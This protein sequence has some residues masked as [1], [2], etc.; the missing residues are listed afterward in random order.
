[1]VERDCVW[2][3]DSS[4][5]YSER[6]LL[7]SELMAHERSLAQADPVFAVEIALIRPVEAF[8]EALGTL[9]HKLL[10]V[11]TE[12]GLLSATMGR[13]QQAELV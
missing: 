11:S 9:F 12:L 3:L 13:S 8:E 4:N 1:M 5:Y 6:V 10:E 7:V 2:I